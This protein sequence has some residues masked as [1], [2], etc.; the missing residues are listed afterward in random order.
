MPEP[1]IIFTGASRAGWHR[2]QNAKRCLQLHAYSCGTK[3]HAAHPT[4]EGRR[5]A[6]IKGT[7]MHL[8]LAQHYAR[9]YCTQNGMDPNSFAQPQDA[10]DF[11]AKAQGED[12]IGELVN[13]V[14]A[15]YKQH[16]SDDPKRMK[17]IGV[18]K[19]YETIIRGKYLYTGRVDL[20]WEDSLGLAWVTDH[21]TTSRLTKSHKLYYSASGQLI[22][23]A[24]LARTEHPEV[25]GVVLNAIQVTQSP[26]FERI[27]LPR[28]P[29]FEKHF[30]QT[31][32]D[33]E[34]AINRQEVSG[35]NIHAWPKAM[36]ELTCYHRYGPCKFL[37]TCRWG[38]HQGVAG[39]WTIE[40]DKIKRCGDKGGNSDTD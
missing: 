11:M 39:D 18:E 30:E 12:E 28:A 25:S 35:R 19:L 8:A 2:I 27:K 38:A 33:T 26:K 40:S 16:F 34:E 10:V 29:N 15:K 22:G 24:Y 23:Y 13:Y 20:I 1:K 6:L 5:P 32:V 17:I 9:M 4:N 7:Y 21:K 31:I 37:D 3:S 14:F 36:N